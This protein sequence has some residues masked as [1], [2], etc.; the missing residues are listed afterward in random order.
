MT[1]EEEEGSEGMNPPNSNTS[2]SS[3]ELTN[4]LPYVFKSDV[5]FKNSLTLFFL[6]FY[7]FIY[8][9]GDILNKENIILQKHIKGKGF[10][11]YLIKHNTTNTYWRVEI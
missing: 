4:Q 11:L 9:R 6:L 2:C 5:K 10:F 1:E 3:G 7:I 8:A